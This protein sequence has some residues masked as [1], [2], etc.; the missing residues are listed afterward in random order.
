MIRKRA[1]GILLHVSS[2]PSPYG[3]GDLGPNARRWVDYLAEAGQSFWQILPLGPTTAQGR[4]SPYL[5][6]SAFAGDPLFVSPAVLRDEGLLSDDDL[7]GLPDFPEDS[8]DYDAVRSH[9]RRLLD[10]AY[11]R[12]QSGSHREGF[13]AFCGREAHWLDDYAVFA[14]LRGRFP[15]QGWRDWPEPLRDRDAAALEELDE[16]TRD[17]AQREKFFQ[18]LFFD[19]WGRLKRYANERGI[20]I[21]GD[22]PFYVG[23]ESTDVWAHPELFKLDAQRHPTHVA[24]VPPDAFSDTGQLWGNPVYNWPVHAE[25]GYDWWIRRLRQNFTLCDIVRIDHFRGFA[26]Y[27]EVPADDDTA[28]GGEWVDGPGDDFFQHLLKYWPFPP[29][30]AEDLGLITADVRELIQRYEL[31]G[32]KVLLFAFDGDSASNPY[33]LHNHVPNSVLYTGTHDNS[34]VRGWF[35]QEAGPE[36]KRRLGDYLGHLPPATEIHWHLIR[37]GMMSVSR[38]LVVPIQ[39]VLGLGAEARMNRPAVEKGNWKWRLAPGAATPQLARR[40][41]G[42]AAT[43]GRD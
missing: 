1:S 14:A 24:G 9:K 22:L 38:L 15:E 21:I 39:D 18:Y 28:V 20:R 6:A 2:L 12:F 26:Q 11:G 43:Y 42:L 30:I 10:A 35:E 29:I 23:G 27:W 19:Q 17:A 37:M 25:A 13:E 8:V 36:E 34:T 3:I 31:P 16:A 33:S 32:M 40:L 4:N 5:A 41:A 7:R